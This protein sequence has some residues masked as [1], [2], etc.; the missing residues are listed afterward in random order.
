VNDID[1]LFEA[2]ALLGGGKA[3]EAA[4]T[5]VQAAQCDHSE[6]MYELALWAVAGKVIPRNLALAYDW[7][8]RASEAGSTE[9]ALLHAYFTAAGTGCSPN[10]EMAFGLLRSLTNTSDVA[11]RQF[12]IL[13]KMDLA[14]NG[15]PLKS[16]SL[17]LR[18]TRPRVATCRQFLT[19]AECDYVVDVGSPFLEPSHVVDPHT[20]KLIPH[21]VRKSHGAMFGVYNED[22]V[23][24]AINRRIAA[25]SGTT[26]GQGEP[27]QLLQYQRGDEYRPHLDA[28]PNEPN[29]RVLTLIIYLSD[30]YGGGE[31]LFLR[32]GFSFRGQKG[33]ALLFANVLPDGRPDPLS[34]HCGMP[35]TRGTKTIA[36]RW[37]RR[38]AFT[39]PAP[40]PILSKIPDLVV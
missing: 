30:D 20:R 24:N 8:G 5:L 23:I 35:V 39:Y 25:V 2:H 27:L 36:T 32:T 22:L 16:G 4:I 9:G 1:L 15:N 28:L 3:K 18:S 37:I 26:S 40:R 7:L 11:A 34:L 29:Q 33:D 12:D 13:D 17:E 21:P 31:T 10:W 38:F 19:T 14:A 6:A